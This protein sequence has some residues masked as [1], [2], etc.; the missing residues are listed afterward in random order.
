MISS[1]GAVSPG[2]SGGV[3]GPGSGSGSGS[4]VESGACAGGG[5]VCGEGSTRQLLS[6]TEDAKVIKMTVNTTV[7]F[8]INETPSYSSGPFLS[9]PSLGFVVNYL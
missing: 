6:N 9:L 2:S 1:I 7:A 5:S 4:G 3:P 8:F